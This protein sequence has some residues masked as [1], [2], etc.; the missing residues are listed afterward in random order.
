MM[1]RRRVLTGVA[2][3]PLVLAAPAFIRRANAQSV[4]DVAGVYSLSG[5]FANVGSGLNDGSKWAIEQYGS[6]AGTS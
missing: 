4:V 6:A 2:A 3:A 1:D 5:T